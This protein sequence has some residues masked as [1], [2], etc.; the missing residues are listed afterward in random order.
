MDC[1][2]RLVRFLVALV[3]VASVRADY[4]KRGTWQETARLALEDLATK[5][6]PGM[7]HG[8][9]GTELD[10]WYLA[11][12]YQGD[13]T[14]RF[15]TVF[16]PMQGEIDVTKPCGGKPW[17]PKPEYD[18]GVVYMMKAGSYSA[19]FLTRIIRS[20]KDQT[21]TAYFGSDDGM[22]AWLNGK[23]II[24][25]DVPR[26]PGPNQETAKLDLKTGD[27]RLTIMPFNN[28]GGHGFYFSTNRQPGS[29]RQRRMQAI[30]QRLRRDFP[31]PEA[32]QQ[33]D[34]ETADQI[35][36]KPWPKGDVSQLAQR[37]AAATRVDT[38]KGK[39]TELAKAC[40]DEAGLTALRKVYY[41]SRLTEDANKV[42][43]GMDI[44]ALRRALTD[45]TERYGDRYP[46]G[47]E[48]A[49]RV[50]A[51]T[52]RSKALFAAVLERHD[53]DAL[54]KLPGLT[55]EWHAL[56][57]DVLLANPLLDFDRVLFI[58]RRGS[59]GLTANWQGNDRLHGRKFDNEIA[60][61]ELRNAE[62]ETTIYKPEQPMFVGDVDLHWDAT[63]MLFST[64]G[65]VCEVHTDGTGFRKVVTEIESYDPCYLPNG[66]L[67]FCSNAGYHAVPCVSGSDY[68]GNI[69]VA[70]LDGTHIRRLCF[71][72]D[73]NWNPSVL[74]NG[75]VLYTRWE[76]T[77]SAHYFA[78]VLM[79]MNPDGTNQMEFYGSNSYWPNSMFYARQIPGSSSKFVAIVSGH[80]GVA[81][82]GE[83]VLFDAARGRHEA[84]GAIQQIPGYGKPVE[85]VIKDNLIGQ[86]W[87]RFLHPWPLDEKYFLVACKRTARDSWGIY[88]A[89]VFDNMVLLKS[90]PGYH[91]L[92]P[93][94][95]KPRTMPAEIANRVDTS[96]K[97]ATVYIHDVYAGQGLRGVPRGAVKSLRLYQYEYAYR[98]VGG[99]NVIGYEG[100][101]DVRRVLGTVPVLPDGSAV[102][103]IPANSPLSIQPL[104]Q[105]GQALAVMR[106]WFVGMP[107]E[108]VSCVGCHEKQNSIA[109]PRKA[110]ASNLAPMS[111]KPWYGPTRGFSF[112]REVQPVLDRRC[113]GCHDGTKPDRPSFKDDG[114]MVGFST[115]QS[116]YSK[117]YL[118]LI[119]YVRRNGPEG[120]YH[121]LTPLE[122]HADTSELIQL[123]RKGHH[124]VQLNQEEWDRLI[125]W[126]DVNVPF[127][128][129]WKE[130][131]P[132]IRDE[133]VKARHE[134]RCK[135][136]GVDEDIEAIPD[137][138][139]GD[140]AF[141]PPKPM[142]VA[143]AK[144]VAV[145]GW[146]FDAKRAAAMQGTDHTLTVDLG[147]G[148][149]L[150]F[151]RIPAGTFVMGDT[152]GYA[153][154][155]PLA[156]VTIEKPFWLL[157]GEITNAQ[158]ACFDPQHDSGVYD[159]RWKDQVNRGYYV[160]QPDKPVIRVS[161]NEAMRFCQWLSTKTGRTFTLPSEAEWEWACRAGTGT[162]LSYGSIT[163]D[164]A[165]FANLA[166][167]TTKELVVTG[168]NP[169]PV[170]NPSPL[171]SYLP[172]DF[173]VN[174]KVLH[175]APPA[176][177]HP[178]AWGLYDMHGNVAEWTRSIYRPYPYRQ[179]DGRNDTAD[180]QARRVVRGGSWHDQPN[181]ARSAFRLP[182]PAWQRVFNVGFR[183]LSPVE[184]T[185]SNQ[186][187]AAR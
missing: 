186:R 120:D 178:N 172:A 68:V 17:T 89:D 180:A 142:P 2:S 54:G 85:P 48:F 13:K 164:F 101:W 106:S 74:E 109:T 7:S 33:I 58:K 93:I 42:Q 111:I 136:A 137:P 79:H 37:Y 181:R 12:P 159:M 60:S 175:L 130:A 134:N 116:R 69:H 16:P 162:P 11:G 38:F 166:D 28:S 32:L 36:S 113:V 151:V 66:K 73:N 31:Q 24:S 10:V 152:H 14:L 146:P 100:P 61:F 86:V 40:R 103:K 8:P 34:W 148:Q 174:D 64:N 67:L 29:L 82:A 112:Q 20:P 15:K 39:A 182:Y 139:K 127:Y 90:V 1:L 97:E 167:V 119:K 21:I 156:A 81:R 171:A 41:L 80:H 163:T 96:N 157:Q 44:A 185:D 30:W 83:F 23:E 145:P 3:L 123:L 4:V 70:D 104:D 110:M 71:D 131:R 126:I 98:N 176:T 141:V 105:D 25:H 63:R 57:K 87:P 55:D 6:K 187:A 135:Y 76:Y 50:A 117:P 129:T 49:R 99:H 140:E 173:A 168:V 118:A 184:K 35:W 153:D 165:E 56:Q 5:S 183:V 77:D 115:A 91:C 160:N 72:Q 94:P 84:G 177:Y 51:F 132:N 9:G 124:G 107:G 149:R 46:R 95:L 53:V 45:L 128:G 102:F 143:K 150:T 138:Y 179:D 43:E 161:W 155:Q 88:L 59:E 144:P 18:D 22:K 169:R 78:R 133:Y 170:R 154:E 147:D 121:V 27:N 108:N 26:G 92:E 125:T 75:R 158:Y 52:A 114:K 62:R 65:T 122:F 47:P 19:T